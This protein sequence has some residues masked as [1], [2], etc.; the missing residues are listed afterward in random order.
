VYINKIKD[1]IIQNAPVE[2]ISQNRDGFLYFKGHKLLTDFLVDLFNSFYS[3]YL[4]L[5]GGKTTLNLNSS[6]LRKKYRDYKPYLDY[7]IF[8]KY[9]YKHRNHIAGLRSTEYALNV[10]KLD[11][12]Q[13]IEYKNYVYLVPFIEN[14]KEI[15]LKT[16]IPSRKA[17]KKYLGGET[18]G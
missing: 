9:I 6:I 4:H 5:N 2:I 18:N 7:L 15:F 13:I 11:S 12:E 8:H 16:I 17:T 1:C 3:K 14:K 10:I